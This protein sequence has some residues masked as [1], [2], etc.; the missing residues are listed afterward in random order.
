MANS[1]EMLQ[2]FFDAFYLSQTM[3]LNVYVS[4]DYETYYSKFTQTEVDKIII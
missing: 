4:I 1:L 3:T 2:F